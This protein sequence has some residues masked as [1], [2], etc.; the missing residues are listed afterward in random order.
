MCNF[1][2]LRRCFP[3]YAISSSASNECHVQHGVHDFHN[4]GMAQPNV[5]KEALLNM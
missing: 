1:K 3:V 2:L 5:V 4:G